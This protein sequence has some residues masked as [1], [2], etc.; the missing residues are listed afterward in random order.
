MV[1]SEG[2]EIILVVVFVCV[3][4]IVIYSVCGLFNVIRW[5]NYEN[6]IVVLNVGGGG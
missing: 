2:D 1:S 4:I 6:V 5:V 3:K